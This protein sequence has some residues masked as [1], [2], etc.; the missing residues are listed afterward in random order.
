MKKIVLITLLVALFAVPAFAE[1][2]NTAGAK[3]DAPNLIRFTQNLTLG[4]EGGKNLVND[5][6]YPDN[7][8]AIEDDYGYFAYAKITWTG[9]LFDFSK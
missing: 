2:H 5:I 3:I 4:L 9:S 8:N 7:K 1:V 6:G